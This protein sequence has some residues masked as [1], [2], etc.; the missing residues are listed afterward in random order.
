LDDENIS[1]FTV[2]NTM[3]CKTMKALFVLLTLFSF[4]LPLSAQE[5]RQG[6]MPPAK[7]VVS[8]VKTGMVAEKYEFIGTVYYVEVS[9]VAS[10]VNGKV[11]SVNFEEGQ[12]VK[13]GNILVGLSAD[14]LE[15]QLAAIRASHEQ[16]L[17]EHEK[18]VADLNRI[19]DLIKQGSVSEQLYDEHRF[20]V[21]G[22]EKKAASIE[23]DVERIKVELGKKRI[24][25]PFDG[26]V[27]ERA[28]DRGEWLSPG[29]KVATIARDDTVDVVVDVPEHMIRYLKQGMDLSV[30]AGGRVVKGEV[31]A[32]VPR[33]D[34]ATRTFP[35]KIRINN[36]ESLKEGMEARVELPVAERKQS[37]IVPRDAV[38]NLFGDTVVFAVVDS[39]AKMI[40]VKVLGYEGEMAG[41]N[42]HGL[43]EGM[44]VVVKGNERLMDG[45][46][47]IEAQNFRK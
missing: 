34:V 22:L 30:R 42:A 44:K 41:V 38:I 39:K 3:K 13:K 27:I 9:D 33:G 10:E 5:K 20:R 16:V 4:A 36:S 1:F 28:V 40:Q 47:V 24:R 7:V 19:E 23:A 15:K 45:Q 8:D 18:A 29:S 17:I 35:L 46:P 25:V 26:V 37:L 21:M 11:E 43:E 2:E 32:V 6:G 14:L 12:R 31:F